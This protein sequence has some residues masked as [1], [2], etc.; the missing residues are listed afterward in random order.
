MHEFYRLMVLR[1]ED[2][3][4]VMGR[5]FMQVPWNRKRQ[6]FGKLLL[7][8]RMCFQCFGDQ[9]RHIEDDQINDG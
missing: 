5:A 9:P 6:Q 7:S 4:D 8:G 1:F 2:V 3:P